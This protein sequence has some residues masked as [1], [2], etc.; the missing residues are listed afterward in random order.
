MKPTFL[1]LIVLI[2]RFAR[3]FGHHTA[4][5]NTAQGCKRRNFRLTCV[6]LKTYFKLTIKLL[7]Y[8]NMQNVVSLLFLFSLD[9]PDLR[10]GL[11][12]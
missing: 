2:E 6:R 3:K 8:I 9:L 10:Q 5:Q 4:R 1:S 12:A 7:N 11:G